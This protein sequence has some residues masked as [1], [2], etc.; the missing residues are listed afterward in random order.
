MRDNLPAGARRIEDAPC[1]CERY[2]FDSFDAEGL[3][4]PNAGTMCLHVDK[5]E[6]SGKRFL[7]KKDGTADL[8]PKTM[9]KKAARKK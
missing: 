4:M 6:F 5:C 3:K 7:T 2:E 9:G 1:G 8:N